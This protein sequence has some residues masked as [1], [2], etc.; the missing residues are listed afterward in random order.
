MSVAAALA[1]VVALICVAGC[2]Q[3]GKEGREA[4]G[5][6]E[7]DS[8]G[9]SEVSE[10]DLTRDAEIWCDSVISSLTLSEKV[11]QLFMPALYAEMNPYVANKIRGYG[12]ENIGG[13]ILL[14][15]DSAGARMVADSLM[16][17][18]KT[19]PFVAIDAEWGLGMR[20]RDTKRYP[21]NRIISSTADENVMYDY[22]REIASQSRELGI[23]MVLGPVLDVASEKSYIGSRS[24]GED[25]HRVA[26]LGVAYARGLEDGGVVSVAKHFPGHGSAKGDSHKTTPMIERSLMMLDSIDLYPFR[27]YIANGLTGV[28]TGHLRVPA[29]DPEMRPAA[30]SRA[31]VTDLLR[32]DMGFDGLVLTDAMNMGGSEGNGALDAIMAGGDIVLAPVDT[33]REI[34]KVVKAVER[35]ELDEDR[36]NQSLRRILLYKYLFRLKS[37]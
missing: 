16:R 33:E 37:S 7:K 12:E 9:E 5:E 35:G 29:I 31:V 23:N 8:V 6:S 2:G 11:G 22:G 3:L 17:Y 13:I 10:S 14:K 4:G 19:F 26:A 15:G 20:L 18:C 1:A 24:F 21:V 28:M 30:V 32:E 27:R 25:P 34:E 36:L